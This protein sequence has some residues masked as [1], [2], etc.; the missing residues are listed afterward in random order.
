[1]YGDCHEVR[2]DNTRIKLCVPYLVKPKFPRKPEPDPP[3]T[4][5]RE[6]LIRRSILE[7]AANAPGTDTDGIVVEWR[8]G[9]LTERVGALLD[10]LADIAIEGVDAGAWS[11]DLIRVSHLLN[12]IGGIETGFVKERLNEVLRDAAQGLVAEN[13]PNASLE[14]RPSREEANA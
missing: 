10:P 8:T 6:E 3:W 13:I 1:M 9:S 2:I 12:E 11:R 4:D 7:A 14:L 5:W